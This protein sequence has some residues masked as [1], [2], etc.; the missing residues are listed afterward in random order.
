MGSEHVIFQMPSSSYTGQIPQ[1]SSQTQ[2]TE[3]TVLGIIHTDYLKCNDYLFTLPDIQT[4][5]ILH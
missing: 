2:E 4:S 1:K 5:K 3:V